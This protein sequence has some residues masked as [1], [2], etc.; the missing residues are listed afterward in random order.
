MVLKALADETRLRILESLLAIGTTEYDESQRVPI[1]LLSM[2][3]VTAST[4]TVLNGTFPISRPLYIVTR[5]S[6]VGLT[7][8]F[9][10]YAQAKA[11]HDI[12]KQ[13][14]FVPLVD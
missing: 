12:I 11:V 14:Y 5:T 6:P 13:Q 4:E 2:G 3:S 8:S 9:I 1:K 7:K 10:D